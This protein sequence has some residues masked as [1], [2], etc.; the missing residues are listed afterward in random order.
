MEGLISGGSYKRTKKKKGFEMS[1]SSVD[2]NT[3]LIYQ[4]L[5]NL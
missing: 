4:F 1:H 2:R 3:L 5:I